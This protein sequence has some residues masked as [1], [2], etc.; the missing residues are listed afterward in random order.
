MAVTS[1]DSR[2]GPT[3]FTDGLE[4]VAKRDPSTDK[5][6]T[7]GLQLLEALSQS[8]QPRGVSEMA[9]ELDLTKSNVHRLVQTLVKTGYVAR[10]ERT[11]KYF[12]SPKLWHLARPQRQYAALRNLI[13][14]TLE[15]LTGITNEA[16]TFAVFEREEI[17][18]I[19]Q[20]DTK[21]SQRLFF[22]P[23]QV[24]PV[25]EIV[26]RGKSLTAFQ[27]L[28]L[29][30]FPEVEARQ[31]ISKIA[32]QL[33]KPADFIDDRMAELV[34]IRV[35]GYAISDGG[36]N[37][38]IRAVAAPVYNRYDK[39]FGILMTFGPT[40]R[41]NQREFAKAKTATRENAE[42]VTAALCKD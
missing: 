41:L 11:E 15:R 25:D 9:A 13:R 28:T 37:P 8:D 10:D 31:I 20:L 4:A 30:T 18:I 36:W 21:S 22:T 12:L 32:R 5:T 33:A 1:K 39:L 16:A 42:L 34:K 14:P 24:L 17:I 7:K 19:D 35:E 38:D 29:S 6:L 23:G 40:E 3:E 27:M 26:L 2:T